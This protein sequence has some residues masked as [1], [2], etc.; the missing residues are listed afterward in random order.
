LKKQKVMVYDIKLRK[1]K[2]I[3]SESV[4]DS[5]VDYDRLVI[6]KIIESVDFETLKKIAKIIKYKMKD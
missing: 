3:N 1:Y 4:D 2:E 6:L 5:K